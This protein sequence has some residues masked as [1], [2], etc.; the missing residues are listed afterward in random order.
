M[1][2]AGLLVLAALLGDGGAP[3][4]VAAARPAV[5]RLSVAF[6][7]PAPG[8]AVQA[9]ERFRVAWS[10][11]GGPGSPIVDRS[12][13]RYEGSYAGGAGVAGAS[14]GGV[15]GTSY[16]GTG[17]AS[18]G[19][20]CKGVAFYRVAAEKHVAPFELTESGLPPGTCAYWTI[21]VTDVNGTRVS[22]TSGYV[23]TPPAGGDGPTV[24][25]PPL[26]G[27]TR[28]PADW[29]Y[30]IAWRDPPGGAQRRTLLE[31]AAPMT[32]AL[33][34]SGVAW[35]LSRT[36]VAD[37]PQVVVGGLA[38]GT[39]YR[40]LILSTA[41]DGS[42]TSTLTGALLPTSLP[43]PC[44]F[45]D[46]TTALVGDGVW[47]WSLLDTA[48]ALPS[49]YAPAD[50]VRTAGIRGMSAAFQVRSVAYSDLS[51]LAAAARANG[52]PIDLTSAYRSYAEQQST[53][54]FYVKALGEAGGLL[55]AARPGHSEHQ[56]G[57]AIDVKAAGGAA[58]SASPDWATTKTGAWM[59]DNAWRFGWVM[60]YPKGTSPSLTCY[61]YE[62]WHFRYV[63][64][65]AAKAIHDARITLRQYLWE[66]GSLPLGL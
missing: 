16:G 60:S 22:A 19:G 23:V 14:A 32:A 8:A 25:F 66:E 33:G 7:D 45:A 38:D 54:A 2:A 55:R 52:T 44:A 1:A 34:C 49:G 15:G 41:P 43:P 13:F 5:V 62:P 35:H 28:G 21:T 56:L 65:A 10:E 26:G 61:E 46:T 4:P 57:T 27:L 30:S 47:A 58:A 20:S 53:Y 42:S 37:A 11:S 31:M 29:S 12:V 64:R 63:G 48:E 18:S 6:T 50:L 36:I 3:Q 17:A 9:G 24:L 51:A 39:C 59:R 40:Y